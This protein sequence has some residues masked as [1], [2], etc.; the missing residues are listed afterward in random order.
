MGRAYP[1]SD[2]NVEQL[3]E[4]EEAMKRKTQTTFCSRFYATPIER[5]AEAVL[6]RCTNELGLKEIP[7]P[8]PVESWIER[9]LGISFG[10]EDLSCLGPDILGAA[11]IAQ[12]EMLISETLVNHE[13]RFRFTSAHELGHFIL[14][15]KLHLAFRDTADEPGRKDLHER[16]ADRFAA[17]FLMPA[18]AVIQTLLQE[19]E[20]R[21]FNA[22][23]LQDVLREGSDDTAELSQ[24]LAPALCRKFNV[25]RLAALYRLRE[26]V[27]PEIGSFTTATATPWLLTHGG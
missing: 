16:E 14:H 13:A 25:S 10:V 3:S 23:A 17:A 19:C 26:T 2:E 24:L 12:R 4:T 18:A 1:T 6:A 27:L 22:A 21:G 5:E 11:F 7:L 8:V 9:P 15:G 20:R